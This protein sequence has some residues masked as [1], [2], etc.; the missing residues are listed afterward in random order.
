MSKKSHQTSSIPS[1]TVCCLTVLLVGIDS[2]R[3]AKMTNHP[4]SV[5]IGIYT[6]STD[7]ATAIGATQ[8]SENEPKH[9]CKDD[10]NHINFELDS[11]MVFCRLLA[12][13]DLSVLV[14]LS[15]TRGL[16]CEILYIMSIVHL[17]PQRYFTISHPMSLS[18]SSSRRGVGTPR[19]NGL[20]SSTSL[21]SR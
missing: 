7:L 3:T 14:E 2:V 5:L 8:V 15:L 11:R 6:T 16:R 9:D 18:P 13:E 17:K 10:P 20:A 19:P 1:N 4:C 12:H 21:R